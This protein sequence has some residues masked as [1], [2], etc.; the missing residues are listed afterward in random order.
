MSISGP[1]SNGGSQAAGRVVLVAGGT[2]RTGEVVLRRFLEQGFQVA[3]SVRDRAKL[4]ATLAHLPEQGANVQVIEA[5]LLEEGGAERAVAQV[6]ERFGRL[7]AVTTLVGGGFSSKP[8][9]ETSLDDL[10]RMME[11]NLYSTYAL[12]RAALPQML[13]QAAATWRR[14]RAEARGTRA[15]AGRCSAR[16]RRRW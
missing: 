16:A 10:R 4:Q 12:C 2:A 1:E 5:D 9:A 6:V 7:D 11:G 15:T 8:F 14:W 3:T 13:A